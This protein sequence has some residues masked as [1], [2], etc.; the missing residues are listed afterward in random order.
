M[1]S[2]G[3]AAACKNLPVTAAMRISHAGA[4]HL[5]D[6]GVEQVTSE[7]LHLSRLLVQLVVG[8]LYRLRS[9]LALQES[10]LLVDVAPLGF[11]QVLLLLLP[12]LLFFVHQ[13]S[14]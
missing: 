3:P 10:L 11:H 6:L 12:V 14:T 9:Q 4:L 7:Q 5:D 8:S 2:A 1:L 13:S